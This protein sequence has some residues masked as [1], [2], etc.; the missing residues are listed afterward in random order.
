MPE[1]TAKVSKRERQARRGN[2]KEDWKR[3]DLDDNLVEHAILKFKHLDPNLWTRHQ[4]E[5]QNREAGSVKDQSHLMVR[6]F[7]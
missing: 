3:Q 1:R 2:I 4:M 6:G 7:P 5:G